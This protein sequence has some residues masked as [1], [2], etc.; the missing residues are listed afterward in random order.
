MGAIEAKPWPNVDSDPAVFLLIVAFIYTS[1]DL[2]GANAVHLV[3]IFLGVCESEHQ[4][5]HMRLDICFKV[6]LYIF[7]I[8]FKANLQSKAMPVCF[9]EIYFALAGSK[10]WQ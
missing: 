3:H 9:C 5:S 7:Q 4:Y 2:L 8:N 10:K 6:L 1:R